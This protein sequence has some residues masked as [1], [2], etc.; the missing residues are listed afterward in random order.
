MKQ[1]S[2]QPSA[3]RRAV[4]VAFILLAG[5]AGPDARQGAALTLTGAQEVPAVTT[6]AKGSGQ[7][8]V[9]SDHTV[10]GSIVTSGFAPTAAHIHEGA[11]GKS[12]PVAIPLTMNAD[13]S[14]VVPPG[15]K[16]SDTQYASYLA[17]NLYVNVHSAA[18]PGGEIRAQ[19]E[20]PQAASSVPRSMGTGY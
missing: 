1:V 10:S 11:P 8:T 16:L 6:G 4:P 18:H 20:P 15:A 7:L 17:G 19:I 5:C 13:G 12:G 14:F 9:A 3:W 2:Q